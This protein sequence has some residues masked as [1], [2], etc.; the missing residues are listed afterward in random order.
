MNTKNLMSR[1]VNR[2]NGFNMQDLVIDL[3][4]MSEED[5]KQ[6]SGGGET[7]TA[8]GG[9]TTYN[10]KTGV[11]TNKGGTLV[12]TSSHSV[13]NNNNNYLSVSDF[14]SKLLLE[15]V[16]GEFFGG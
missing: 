12:I 15:S 2:V 7:I 1:S 10:K 6:I 4:E 14:D 16:S 8:T 3:V 5:L 11:V 9:T 13:A